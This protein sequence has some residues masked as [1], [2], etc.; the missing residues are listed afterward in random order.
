MKRMVGSG[1]ALED[2]IKRMGA[3]VSSAVQRTIDSKP[4]PIT[5]DAEKI[6]NEEKDRADHIQHYAKEEA[7]RWFFS[8]APV[9]CYRP[10]VAYNH[11]TTDQVIRFI[12]N[13]DSFIA[14]E[15]EQY[16]VRHARNINFR[17]WAIGVTRKEYEA[18]ESMPGEHHT[19]R[20][21]ADSLSNGEKKV[22]IHL[23]K[24]GQRFEGKIK[25]D[26]LRR[27]DGYS[28]YDLN[29][30]ATDRKRFIEAF[31]RSARILPNDIIKITYGKKTL[32]EKETQ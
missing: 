26:A 5:A 12:N 28:Y 8:R 17:L 21:I 1:E 18:L 24:D 11:A 14:E 29:L 32:Y 10:Q 16:V 22:T 27:S 23:L 2:I 31:G 20:A 13:P 19:I 4:V 9:S 7:R 30:D 15:A 25:A 6:W 3:A